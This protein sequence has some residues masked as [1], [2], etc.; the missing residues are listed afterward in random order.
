MWYTLLFTLPL[1]TA[2][3]SKSESSDLAHV[4]HTALTHRPLL[5]AHEHI[6]HASKQHES[7][8]RGAYLPQLS[9]SHTTFFDREHSTLNTS[10]HTISLNGSQLIFSPNGPQ[11]QAKIAATGTTQAYHRF[12]ASNNQ[13]RHDT[14]H[15]FLDAWLLQEKQ[16][17]IDALA[18]KSES[19]LHRTVATTALDQTNQHDLAKVNAE[20]AQQTVILESYDHACT[21]ATARLISSMGIDSLS[22]VLHYQAEPV[23][24]LDELDEYITHALTH[25]PELKEQSAVIEH[26]RLTAR[27]HRLSYLPSFH[28]SG[29]VGQT[30]AGSETK[31]GTNA[32]VSLSARWEFF[33]GM[34]KKHAAHAADAHALRAELE[35]HELRLRIRHEVTAAFEAVNTAASQ[36][37]ATDHIF[38]LEHGKWERDHHLF[39]LGSLPRASYEE[40]HHAYQ[41][42]AHDLRSA[43]VDLRKK[44]ETLA[45]HCGYPPHLF[46][47]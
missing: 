44:V 45:F 31:Q 15:A 47:S 36:V 4:A 3:L 12:E 2:M 32:H 17:L 29:G 18:K 43:Q 37:R 8:A 16:P 24:A 7:Q 38:Q 11:L 5:K 42:A 9:L 6:I 33:D 35:E 34:Q 14:V 20:N 41:K 30:F 27:S 25:R 28:V 1:F 21:T 19:A 23:P 13:V 26:H 40:Q 22:P 46:E 39:E 10:T